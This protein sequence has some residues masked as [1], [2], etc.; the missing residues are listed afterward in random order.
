MNKGMATVYIILGIAF[1]SL[2][3]LFVSQMGFITGNWNFII[4]HYIA[5]FTWLGVI[6]LGFYWLM[7]RIFVSRRKT[8]FPVFFLCGMIGVGFS[9]LSQYLYNNNI[10]LDQIIVAPNTIEEFMLIVIIIW[11]VVGI[12]VGSIQK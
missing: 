10:W 2:V 11:I 8:F 5:L 6:G 1:F 4:T 9:G 3:L 12:I 7:L